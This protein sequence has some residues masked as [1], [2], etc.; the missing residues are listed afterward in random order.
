MF[1]Y[2]ELIRPSICALTNFLGP[3]NDTTKSLCESTPIEQIHTS[4]VLPKL[5]ENVG[6]FLINSCGEA[7]WLVKDIEL[8][9]AIQVCDNLWSNMMNRMAQNEN[10]TLTELIVQNLTILTD[11]VSTI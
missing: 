2:P 1:S 10:C 11:A 4:L 9:D 3:I 5:L 6:N 7:T 8:I